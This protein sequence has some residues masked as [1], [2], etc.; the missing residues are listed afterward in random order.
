MTVHFIKTSALRIK[1]FYGGDLTNAWQLPLLNSQMLSLSN[2][3]FNYVMFAYE[4][5]LEKPIDEFEEEFQVAYFQIF[6]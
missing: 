3:F 1:G 6:P 2:V 5:K 4:Y